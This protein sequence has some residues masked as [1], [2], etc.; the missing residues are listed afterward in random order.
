MSICIHMSD[1]AAYQTPLL[2]PDTSD[3]YLLLFA[4]MLSSTTA[5]LDWLAV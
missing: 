1:R 2:L 5:A 4:M 3:V